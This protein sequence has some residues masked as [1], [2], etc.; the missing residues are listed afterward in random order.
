MASKTVTRSILCGG[1]V[2]NLSKIFAI[3]FL[4]RMTKTQ[5]NTPKQHGKKKLFI[6]W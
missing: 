4:D 2:S 6:D 3:T 1:E 5:N